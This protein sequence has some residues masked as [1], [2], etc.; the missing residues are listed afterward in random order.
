ML[1]VFD[2]LFMQLFVRVVCVCVCFRVLIN[3]MKK[4]YENEMGRNIHSIIE[5]TIMSFV[6]GIV[7]F[8]KL[9]L[10]RMMII[11][12]SRFFPWLVDRTG[13]H[14]QIYRIPSGKPLKKLVFSFWLWI[15][16]YADEWRLLVTGWREQI[17]KISCSILKLITKWL[18]LQ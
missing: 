7:F 5:H 8:Y 3:E 12:T 15:L 11:W 1:A 4:S 9:I 17:E 10:I 18:F 14:A 16:Q 13:R 2:C 6:D